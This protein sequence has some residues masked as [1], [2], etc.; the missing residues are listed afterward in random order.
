VVVF[1]ILEGDFGL[2]LEVGE[3]IEVLEHQVLHAL[4]VD[5]DLDLV[6]L[7][8]VLQLTLL[9]T[10]L[11]LLVLQLLLAND[12]EVVDSLSLILI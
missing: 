2:L 3:L 6:L 1:S 5:L 12:P 11:S 7:I 9:V 8:Q 10:Q 4:L